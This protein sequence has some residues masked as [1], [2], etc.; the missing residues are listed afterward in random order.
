M[1]TASLSAKSSAASTPADANSRTR[2]AS[3]GPYA[4]SSAPRLRKE[5]WVVLVG[6]AEWVHVEA[7]A[8]VGPGHV[9]A[10]EKREVDLHDGV[11]G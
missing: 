8:L 4:T 10:R 7:H 6:R 5:A 9:P 3:P 2:W 1:S 11:E